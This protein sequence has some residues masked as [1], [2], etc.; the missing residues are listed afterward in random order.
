MYKPT[1]GLALSIAMLSISM[2]SA[3]ASAEPERR[4]SHVIV[5][6]VD[7]LSPDGVKNAQTPN[8]DEMMNNGSWSMGARG[9]FPTTSSANWASILT[10]VGPEQH[11]VTSNDWRVNNFD[12]PAS[13]IGSGGFYPSIF[14]VISEQRP[15]WR[16]GSI[17]NWSGFADLYDRSFVTHDANGQTEEETAELAA[18]YIRAAKP[19]FLFVHLDNVDHVGHAIGH[20]TPEYY[21]AV[22]Q[23]D[24][25]I[26][27]IRQAVADAGI[28]GETVIL[29]TSDHGG[30]GRGHGGE[31][32][33]EL[34]VPWIAHGKGIRKG[35]RL[36]LPI[37]TFDTPA[38]A[39]WLL[40]V[41]IPYAW[42]G[43]PVRPMLEGERMP[44]QAYRISSF[45]TAPLI[46]PA[47]EGN[48]PS[49]GLFVDR[50]AQMTI[51][52]PNDAGEIRYT[53]DGSA[54]T[55]T[56][57]LY[58]APLTIERN[59]VARAALFV[60]GKMASAPTTALF[61]I[62]DLSGEEERGVVYKAYLLPQGTVRLPDF[63]KLEPAASGSSHELSIDGLP[64]PRQTNVAVVFD[65][66]IHLEEAGDYRFSLASDD[67]S[68][69]YIDDKVIVDNDGDH[70][71][72]T[73]SG[74][75]TLDA[76]KH[77]IRVEYFNAS[78]GAW[79]GSYYEGPGV[80]RQFIDPNL[81]TPR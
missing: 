4:A 30:V 62:L 16:T 77:A 5:I 61:R 68:K 75:V 79:L 19:E 40:G 65:G 56:S 17:Y 55:G 59:T 73:V 80:P 28:A 42:L 60:D 50:S 45:Y 76:G 29:V 64:L 8:I 57:A 78:G 36:D 33:A 24:H 37:N 13:V 20:G 7:G 72:I 67:G 66:F 25:N 21:T 23:A 32:L 11:G 35:V 63:S 74:G 44:V 26:G 15:N 43:R 1:R 47:G 46:E 14:Q 18:E 41:D 69:L 10:G 54:P 81:L 22:A 2:W 49:G 71:V 6:G 70:G 53:L 48:A 39:A 3:S 51:R 27:L 52:N 9:V 31:T 38:T 34:E 58:T 12:V